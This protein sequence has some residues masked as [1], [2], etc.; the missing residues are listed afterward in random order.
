MSSGLW[1]KINWYR[2]RL[3]AMS[4]LEILHRIVEA[5]K[6]WWDRVRFHAG[7]WD[8][9]LFSSI[10]DSPQTQKS[11][12]SDV[13]VI[14]S[15]TKSGVAIQDRCRM[16]LAAPGWLHRCASRH[17]VL[18]SE[19]IP[20]DDDT[21]LLPILPGLRDALRAWHV[22]DSLLAEWSD[23]ARHMRT[24]TFFLLGREWPMC[25]RDRRWHLDPVTQSFWPPDRF[26]FA[27]PYRHAH[28][29][30]D[31]KYVWELNRL[32]HLQPVAALAFV[33]NDPDLA[34]EC[35]QE[36]ES[37]IDN[38]TP[39]HGV[40]W[41][42]GIELALRVVSIAVVTTLL[43]ASIALPLRTKIANCLRE[44]GKGIARYPSRYSSA[45]NHRVAEGL[46]LFILGALGQMPESTRWKKQGWD[47]LCDSAMEQIHPDGVG[48]EQAISYT[49]FTLDMLML[50]WHVA[51]TMGVQIP[52]SYADRVAAGGVYLRWFTDAAGNQPHIGD[53]DNGRVLGMYRRDENYVRSV[54]ESVAVMTGRADLVPPCVEPHLRQALFGSATAKPQPLIGTH[55]FREGGYTV[56]RHRVGLHEMMVAMDHAPLGFLSIAAHGHADALAVWFHRDGQPILVDAGTYL[57]HAGGDDRRLFRSTAAHNTLAVESTDSSLMSGAFNWS[58]K[59]KVTLRHYHVT[60]AEWGVEAEHDGYAARFGC[61][62]HRCLTVTPATGFVVRDELIGTGPRHVTIGFLLHPALDVRQAADTI[63]LCKDGEVMLRIT[64]EG[65]LTASVVT[66]AWYAPRFGMKEPT[67][68]LV[69]S[70]MMAPGQE[71]TTRFEWAVDQ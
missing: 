68:R 40:A 10:T 65:S 9:N 15:R 42:S 70:G 50:G 71:F 46:G 63:L 59:A 55:H 47:I 23:A 38:N 19:Q 69:F 14:A 5:A 52:T 25:D 24:G 20:A 29:K 17:D 56:G 39:W 6:R 43:D 66:N 4:V 27:I 37:W 54:L 51:R 62:H 1:R 61:L 49:A 26:C 60:E 33:R 16:V 18:Y 7:F 48:V 58:K 13:F 22:P 57:Y 36:L 32:Q 53:D 44:H 41:A 8:S 67:S 30:G 3:A 34:L 2:H 21:I 12:R 35:V 45:N 31:V 64:H 11:N 28:D